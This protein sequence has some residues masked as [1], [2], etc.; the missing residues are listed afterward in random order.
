MLFTFSRA[1]AGLRS[2]ALC[3]GLIATAAIAGPGGPDHNHGAESPKST[4][5]QNPRVIAVSADHQLVGILKGDNLIVY[6][7]RTIDNSPITTATLEFEAN[8]KMHRATLLA[9]GTY[10]LPIA[11]LGSG[12]EISVIAAISGSNVDLLSGTLNIP[13]NRNGAAS[14]PHG[15]LSEFLHRQISMEALLLA[16]A[17]TL[18]VGV[19]FGFLAGRRRSAAGIAAV[20]ALGLLAT[21]PSPSLAGPGGPDHSHG[22]GT[23]SSED[24]DAP[25]RRSDGLIFL[26]KPTQRLFELRTQRAETQDVS[27]TMGIAGVVI[28]D[29]S[30]RVFVQSTLGG[31]LSAPSSGMPVRGQTVKAGDILAVITPQNPSSANSTAATPMRAPISGV[32]ASTFGTAG[33]TVSSGERIFEIIDPKRTRIEADLYQPISMLPGI[34]ALAEIPRQAA[35]PVTLQGTVPASSKQPMT[36]IF[37]TQGDSETLPVDQRVRVVIP[38][39]KTVRGFVVPREAVVQAY[40]GIHVVFRHVAPELF[41]PTPVRFEHLDATRVAVTAG[42]MDGDQIVVQGALLLNQVR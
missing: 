23:V 10:S 34:E 26:P 39:G 24:G 41:E 7:D 33:Q 14:A 40:N 22:E 3:A 42:I 21:Q 12:P 19:V 9:D 4:T 27:K 8:G 15:R 16:A 5:K 30:A 35:V 18:G 25:K 31:T 6:L 29:P 28:S 38:T 13:S 2:L 11:L 37:K 36:A 20:M 32:I 1:R 17:G